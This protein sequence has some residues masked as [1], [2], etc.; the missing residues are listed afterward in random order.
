MGNRGGSLRAPAAASV[1]APSSTLRIISDSSRLCRASA[2]QLLL[3]DLL[4][5][6]VH[7]AAPLRA[8]RPLH[9]IGRHATVAAT[10]AGQGESSIGKS[11]QPPAYECRP[12][13]SGHQDRIAATGIRRS[14]HRDY[15]ALACHRANLYRRA[16]RA[17][18]LP[19]GN[20]RTGARGRTGAPSSHRPERG[21]RLPG[22][23]ARPAAGV[24]L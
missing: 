23:R 15:R 17:V 8:L 10:R 5:E 7:G 16:L 19:G 2:D 14:A 18:F 4:Q 13:G 9:S 12:G 1:N 22:L 21:G 20:R 24:S 3:S 6:P 11:N